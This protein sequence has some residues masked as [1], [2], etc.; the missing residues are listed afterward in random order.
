ML[1]GTMFRRSANS[2]GIHI[3]AMAATEEPMAYSR[4][5]HGSRSS[6]RYK[7]EQRTDH[8]IPCLLQAAD[9]ARHPS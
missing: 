2:S 3:R 1:C 9:I 8:M 7:R 6:Q 4:T 5:S